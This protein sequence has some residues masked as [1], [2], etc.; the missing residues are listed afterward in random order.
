MCK[1]DSIKWTVALKKALHARKKEKYIMSVDQVKRSW[2]GDV[3]VELLHTQIPKP[4]G[5]QDVEAQ[6]MKE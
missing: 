2:G 5:R 3:F 1:V 6:R 4:Y